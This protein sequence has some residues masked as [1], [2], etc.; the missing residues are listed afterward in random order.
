MK[1]SRTFL[2]AENCGPLNC[3]FVGI[4]KRIVNVQG[5]ATCCA[6][7]G[8]DLLCGLG[9]GDCYCFKSCGRRI[10]DEFLVGSTNLDC[11]EI[12]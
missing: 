5:I 3:L 12:P 9:G 11:P 8:P 1:H 7:C 4:T 6:S 2:F 10:P